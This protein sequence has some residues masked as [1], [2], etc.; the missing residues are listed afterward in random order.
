MQKYSRGQKQE[1]GT[2]CPGTPVFTGHSVPIGMGKLCMEGFSFILA[3]VRTILESSL[4]EN[5][6]NKIFS[7]RVSQILPVTFPESAGLAQW[8]SWHLWCP[9]SPYSPCGNSSCHRAGCIV[10]VGQQCA[11]YLKRPSPPS[12]SPEADRLTI[13]SAL[14]ET[15]FHKGKGIF[16]DMRKKKWKWQ[17]C[18]TCMLWACVRNQSGLKEEIKLRVRRV[19]FMWS[20][21]SVVTLNMQTLHDPRQCEFAPQKGI[22]DFS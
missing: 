9:P 13:H 21:W 22:W 18:D 19:W 17:V 6:S 8:H 2:G 16:F 7:L 4:L 1:G 5:F 10:P 14:Q 15:Y 11:C 3:K 12:I 20:D